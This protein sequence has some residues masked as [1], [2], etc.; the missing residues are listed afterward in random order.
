MR[1]RVGGP[2]VISNDL[3]VADERPGL[4]AFS[5]FDPRRSMLKSS[6][7]ARPAAFVSLVVVPLRVPSPDVMLNDTD[8]PASATSLSQESLS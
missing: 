6:N 3:L 1:R 5:F 4:E 2:N 7:V 8:T